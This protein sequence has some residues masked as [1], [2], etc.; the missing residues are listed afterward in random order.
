[1]IVEWQSW[2]NMSRHGSA[3]ARPVYPQQ[4]T[5]LM[6]AGMAVACNTGLMHC[7]KRRARVAMIYSITSSARASSIG[8]MV[9]PSALA[10]LRLK[11]DESAPFQLIEFPRFNISGSL[12]MFDATRLASSI[13]ICF[14]SMA[15]ASVERP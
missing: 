7:N 6:T 9:R 3:M 8:G 10:V 1:L 12:A 15:S 13:V 11:C 2:V 4:R 5:Y 14:A